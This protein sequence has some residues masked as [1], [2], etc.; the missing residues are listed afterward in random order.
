[1]V[2]HRNIKVSGY[3]WTE[4]ANRWS[5]APMPGTI[6]NFDGLDFAN[7]GGDIRRTQTGTLARPTTFRRLI[8]PSVFTTRVQVSGLRRLDSMLS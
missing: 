8:L 1:M 4:S 2:D 7:F 5:N 6:A 3:G